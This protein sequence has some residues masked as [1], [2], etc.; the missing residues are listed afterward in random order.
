MVL[1]DFHLTEEIGKN[2]ANN[3]M[4]KRNEVVGVVEMVKKMNY[5]K[6]LLLC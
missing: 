3:G 5:L 2:D 1:R 4:M 6:L